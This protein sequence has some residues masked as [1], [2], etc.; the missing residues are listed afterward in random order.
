MEKIISILIVLY[1]RIECCSSFTID[2]STISDQQFNPR[3]HT[4]NQQSCSYLTY[5]SRMDV[6]SKTLKLGH[7]ESHL[8]DILTLKFLVIL[9][10]DFQLPVPLC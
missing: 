6:I 10:P 2:F 1:A 8:I 9:G 5:L 3:N 7:Y 4:I